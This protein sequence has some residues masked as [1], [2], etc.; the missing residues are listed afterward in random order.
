V[1]RGVGDRLGQAEALNNLGELLA[2]SA[3]GQQARDHYA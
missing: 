3:A 1:F 2:C